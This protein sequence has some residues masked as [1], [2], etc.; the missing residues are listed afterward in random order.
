MQF[1]LRTT[2]VFKQRRNFT[3]KS[4]GDMGREHGLEAR[5]ADSGGG[6]F[7][8]GAVRSWEWEGDIEPLHIITCVALGALY[9]PA[10]GSGA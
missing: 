7:G 3:T 4:G 9:A 8:G 5:M 1:N 6:V 10:A 2:V